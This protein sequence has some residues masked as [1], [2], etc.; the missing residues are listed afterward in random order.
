MRKINALLS[1]LST[2]LVLYHAVLHGIRMLSMGRIDVSIDF[3][4]W[5]LMGLVILHAFVSLEMAATEIMKADKRKCK[6]YFKLNIS[7]MI[8]RITG[9]LMLIFAGLHI[10]GATKAMTPPQ[11]VHAIVPPLFFIIVLVHTAFSTSKAFITLGIG[12]ARTVKVIDVFMKVICAI[13]LVADIVGFYLYQ[14]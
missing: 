1:L 3:L 7:I 11:I 13:T 12:N 10:A 8:Q 4:S 6:T 9:I 2:S 5:V 14:V